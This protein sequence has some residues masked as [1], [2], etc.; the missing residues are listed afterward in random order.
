MFIVD[1]DG[2]VLAEP[3]LIVEDIATKSFVFAQGILKGGAQRPAGAGDRFAGRDSAQ[4]AGEENHRHWLILL[5]RAK[6]NEPLS[7][8]RLISTYFCEV[9]IEREKGCY[10]SFWGEEERNLP[11]I[12]QIGMRP[13]GG[14]GRRRARAP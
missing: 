5:L 2:D 3:A 4:M 13:Q 10:G 12:R 8:K 6:P 1:E 11:G 9:N 14:I 7:S